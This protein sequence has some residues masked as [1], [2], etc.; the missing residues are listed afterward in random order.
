MN[1]IGLLELIV[2]LVDDDRGFGRKFVAHD[3]ADLNIALFQILDSLLRQVVELGFVV[4]FQ[5]FAF[6]N[7]PVEVLV[8]D[9]IFAKTMAQLR[10]NDVLS[11]ERP[12]PGSKQC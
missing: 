9:F 1:D 8:A 11:F 6:Q 10:R 4:Q 2:G 5:V 3:L 12:P 7:P